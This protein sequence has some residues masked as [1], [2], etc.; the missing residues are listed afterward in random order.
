MNNIT[1]YKQAVIIL[2]LLFCSGI[3]S[4][5]E[6][7][8]DEFLLTQKSEIVQLGRDPQNSSFR[9]YME[10]F[11]NVARQRYADELKKDPA[12]EEKIRFYVETGEQDLLP[13]LIDE[14]LV[15]LERHINDA[16][17]REILWKKY[18]V[19]ADGYF[20]ELDGPVVMFW[21]LYSDKVSADVY[22][23]AWERRARGNLE[24]VKNMYANVLPE[25]IIY[26]DY[27]DNLLARL[28]PLAESHEK[29]KKKAEEN[30]FYNDPSYHNFEK[31]VQEYKEE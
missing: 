18:L 31:F 1:L 13:Y 26:K 22:R 28:Y 10:E 5:E 6:I 25:Q 9:L 27:F 16:T 29:L 20:A 17:F 14:E 11:M 23:E 3:P 8:K 12:F 15:Y 4:C 2:S 24:R 30:S 7:R 19:E 21:L